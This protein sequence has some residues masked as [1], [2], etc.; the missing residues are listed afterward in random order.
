[1][2]LHF[3]QVTSPL[4]TLPP[5][6]TRRPAAGATSAQPAAQG[7][8]ATTATQGNSSF[9]SLL[10]SSSAAEEPAATAAAPAAAARRHAVNARHRLP[11]PP[12]YDMP[13][14]R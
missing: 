7:T 9:L 4:L 5:A 10:A 6:P 14:P 1:M 11:D 2:A 8:N 12:P 13:Y 3:N